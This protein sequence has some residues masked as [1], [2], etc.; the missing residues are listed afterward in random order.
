MRR[1]L[2]P[3]EV[4]AALAW[5]CSPDSGGLTGAVIPVD[6]GLSA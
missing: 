1:L 2:E 4:A 3:D 6:A 5:L